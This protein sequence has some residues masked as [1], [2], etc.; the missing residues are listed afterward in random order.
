MWIFQAT[1]KRNTIRKDLDMVKKENLKIESE[2]LLMPAQ[3]NS[4]RT[5][6]VEAT[7]DA[8]KK[9]MIYKL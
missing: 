3:N 1:N 6:Y 9:Q 8:T 5:N 4:M 2:F 7:M